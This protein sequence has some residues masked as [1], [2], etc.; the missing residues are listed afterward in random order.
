[1]IAIPVLAHRVGTSS[2]MAHFW[3][4]DQSAKFSADLN[5]G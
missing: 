5:M 2:V 4:I 1:V 3:T